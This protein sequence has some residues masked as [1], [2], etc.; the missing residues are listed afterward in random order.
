MN[1]SFKRKAD[2]P[3]VS[4]PGSRTPLLAIA[5]VGTFGVLTTLN[6]GNAPGWT[7]FD[8]IGETVAATLAALACAMRARSEYAVPHEPEDRQSR[9]RGWIVWALIAAGVGAWAMGQAGWT[10]WEAAAGVSPPAPSVLDA[11]FLAFPLLAVC[12]LLGMVQ[13][14]AGRLSQ[15]RAVAEG[16][17]IAG[18]FLL[19]NWVLFIGPVLAE[20]TGSAFGEAVNLAY[21]LLDT[22]ALGAVLFVATRGNA[23][24]PRGLALLGLGIVCLAVADSAFWYLS[25][26]DSKFPGVTGL[27]T[28]WVAGFMLIAFAA[29]ATGRSHASD[30]REGDGDAHAEARSRSK[31]QSAPHD[32]ERGSRW[33]RH[34]F[35][36]LPA[37][38][39]ALGI[40]AVL[41]RWLVQ[42]SVSSEGTLLAIMAAV[43][44]LGVLLYLVVMY[45][46]EA[47]T[48]DLRQR[49]AEV[50]ATERYYRALVQ[51]SSDVVMVVEEDLT[52]S[53]L[54][55]S[56]FDIFGYRPQEL[57]GRELN[58]LGRSGAEALTTALD[59]STLVPVQ[60]NR[61]E[62]MLSDA[63]GRVRYADS[64]ITNRVGDPH[65]GAFVVNTR[66]ATDQVALAEQLRHQAFHDPLTGLANRALLND[67][68]IH[69]FAR[70]LREGSKVA[71]ITL[72][73]DA[74]KRVND[75][76][77]H[78]VGDELLRTVAQRLQSV[79]RA[80]DTVARI[81]GDEFVVLLDAVDAA[82]DAVGLAERLHE[83]MTPKFV[84]G[85]SE[86]SITVS[87]GVACGAAQTTSI[88]QLLC[89]A[90]IAL[91]A[92]KAGGRDAV[93]LFKPGMHQQARE[94]YRLQ[95][96][97]RKA[98]EG[99]EL[100]LLY[101]PEFDVAGGGLT[102]FEALVRWNHPTHGLMGPERFIP[103]AEESGLIAP[104]GRWVLEEALRQAVAWE[105]LG[106]R[107]SPL[108]ISVNVSGAQLK[109][110]SFAVDVKDALERTGM[111]PSRV[112]LEIT[113]TALVEDSRTVIEVLHA[114]KELGVRIAIDDFGTGYASFAYLRRVPV[115]ILKVDRSFV[116]SSGQDRRSRELLQ[117]IVGIGHTLSLVTIGE[118]IERPEQLATLKDIGCDLAQGYLLGRPLSVQDAG[119]LI[120]KHA[121]TAVGRGALAKAR[122]GASA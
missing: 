87:I 41:V 117:A 32:A 95:A 115:D 31:A 2:R 26:V 57:I 15:M 94:R 82:E 33:G 91:Y 30:A 27:D 88:E 76:H 46:N 47:L 49:T 116:A 38:P 52:I 50:R 110:P 80:Q 97:L 81:G 108:T 48:R 64:T 120:A 74:F 89:D 99:E 83:A 111:D 93:E 119:R 8:N 12:G 112:V 121:R 37:L 105:E 53:Y 60:A 21:P 28:G 61:V 79:A 10:V 107:Q 77:G 59:R 106:D 65:I 98:L 96:D 90:D 44:G 23:D 63:T 101:Q 102:G 40:L 29:L 16:L 109:A 114:L 75:T 72:D 62:W 71:V 35:L 55:D 5:A 73:V 113:E 104:L 100:W 67:R 54:S 22:V 118:G 78:E 51:H 84:L 36:A 18:G 122:P 66:D 92:V 4:W 3:R 42:G 25:A 45:E 56:V 17:F 43:L 24:P 86:Q 69:A 103:V 39:A 85:E 68:A 6:A 70:S 1:R 34:A 58:A 7:A 14:P 19:L 13:T 9:G 11:G 20:G